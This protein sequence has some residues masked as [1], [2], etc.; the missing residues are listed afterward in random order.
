MNQPLIGK[1]IAFA[2]VVSAY[3]FYVPFYAIRIEQ[4]LIY[5]VF[6][7]FVLGGMNLA[8]PRPVRQTIFLFSGFLLYG[9]FWGLLSGNFELERY[10]IGQIERFIQPIAVMLVAASIA[11][12]LKPKELQDLLIKCL[13]LILVANAV[14]GLLAF[15]DAYGFFVINF[16]MFRTPVG[17][18]GNT[19]IRALNMGRHTAIFGSPFEAGLV[20]AFSIFAYFYLW[21]IDRANFW[22]MIC[23]ALALIGSIVAVT[24]VFFIACALFLVFLVL[25]FRSSKGLWTVC[26]A[27]FVGIIGWGLLSMYSEEWKGFGRFTR[28][29]AFEEENADQTYKFTAGRFSTEGAGTLDNK[30][31]EVNDGLPFGYGF[32]NLGVVDNAY[33]EISLIGGLIGIVFLPTIIFLNFYFGWRSRFQ[34]EGILLYQMFFFISIAS[35]G[36][37]ALT[38]NRFCL[39]FFMI[40]TLSCFV[41]VRNVAGR[42]EGREEYF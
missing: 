29:F 17:E 24:K 38:K 14:I 1:R 30:I 32:S 21:L 13:S 4:I 23:V 28:Y 25:H 15:L 34:P 41:A 39:L 12:K 3:G 5:A 35:V 33:I 36:A 26:L 31:Y 27:I 42:H 40:Y 22:H 16:D 9:I 2:L 8:W 19:A 18:R 37:P 20:Y 7:W 10:T 6:V 11:D